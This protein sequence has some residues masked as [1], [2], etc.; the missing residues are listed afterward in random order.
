MSFSISCGSEMLMA[1]VRPP[2]TVE[3]PH[4]SNLTLSSHLDLEMMIL[5]SCKIIEWKFSKSVMLR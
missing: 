5:S 3:A 1:I 4:F 2:L